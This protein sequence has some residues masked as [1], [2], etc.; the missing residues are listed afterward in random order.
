MPSIGPFVTGSPTTAYG[1]CPVIGAS[2]LPVYYPQAASVGAQTDAL[3]STDDGLH[4]LGADAKDNQLS[5][6]GVSI[7]TGICP[8]TKPGDST[9]NTATIGI[10]LATTLNQAALGVTT[11][12]IDQVVASP[13]SNIAFVT[14]NSAAATGILP[15]YTPSTSPG[16]VGTITPVQLSGK[17]QSPVAGIFSP[18]ETIFFVSTTGDNL[19]HY[20]D[21]VALQDTQTIN[22]GLVDANGNPVPVQMMAVKPRSQL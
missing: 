22:P 2:S 17:A 10:K 7:P 14:Y 16:S 20:V 5:D 8:S 19:I 11:S 6:I 13:T 9:G 4:I 21:P 1:F 3:A 15:A 18:N 12:E